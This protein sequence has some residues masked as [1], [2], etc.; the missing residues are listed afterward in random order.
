MLGQEPFRVRRS[1]PADIEGGHVVS[2]LG[3]VQADCAVGRAQADRHLALLPGKTD[4]DH[5][6]ID[7]IMQITDR[8]GLGIEGSEVAGLPFHARG[9]EIAFK[10]F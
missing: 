7:R 5:V 4:H 6:R 9:E 1:D 8:K 3:A 10:P 2:H